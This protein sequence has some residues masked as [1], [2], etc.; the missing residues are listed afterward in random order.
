[1]KHQKKK[2]QGCFGCCTAAQIIFI[3][4]KLV[5]VVSW[6]WWFIFAPAYISIVSDIVALIKLV[7]VAVSREK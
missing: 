5:N 3:I 7:I 4:L 2:N 6:P 1:M